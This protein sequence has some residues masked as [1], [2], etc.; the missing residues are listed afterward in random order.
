MGF[1][2]TPESRFCSDQPSVVCTFCAAFP[3]IEIDLHCLLHFVTNSMRMQNPGVRSAA[4]GTLSRCLC[5][6]KRSIAKEPV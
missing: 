4:Y 6:M 5:E 2:L 3:V 1:D